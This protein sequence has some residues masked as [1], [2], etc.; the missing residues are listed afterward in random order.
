MLL[1]HLHRSDA[2]I[3][4]YD[5]Q[6]AYSAVQ[7]QCD[8][9]CSVDTCFPS[10]RVRDEW[11]PDQTYVLCPTVQSWPLI[12]GYHVAIGH[13]QG[14]IVLNDVACDLLAMFRYPRTCDASTM[15]NESSETRA[16]IHDLVQL[17]V[18]QPANDSVTPP[19][20]QVL[21]AWLHITD[22]CN[23]RCSYC[24]LPHL[25]KDM[26]LT[27]GR[28][29]IDATF[30]SA[31]RH[32]YAQVKL[33]Y[34]G[35]E[36]LL[37]FKH[38]CTLHRYACQVARECGIALTG[39]ILSNGTLLHHEH[40]SEMRT[41]GLQLMISLD[42]VGVDHDQQ[43]P[44]LHGRG[45]FTETERGISLALT[46]GVIPDIS[47]TVTGK[48]GAALPTLMAWILERDLPF[49]I[50]FYREHDLS[51]TYEDLRC[52]DMQLIAH[53]QAAYQIIESHLPRRSLLNAL[54]D[55]ANGM[56]PH[57]HVCGAGRSYLVFDVNGQV[58]K[59]QMQMDYTVTDAYTE[60][61]LHL[62]RSDSIGVRNISVD[63]K[64]ECQVCTWKQWC[65][66]GCPLVTFRTTGRYDVQSPNCTLYKTLFPAVIRLEG[67]RLLQ[68]GC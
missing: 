43:R 51:A 14:A 66:G 35:G 34:A 22:R 11:T 58:S 60:D 13:D 2:P 6:Q 38:I 62:V 39:V 52:E 64:I 12:P 5:W 28:A 40:L 4:I 27:I 63:D 26:P 53:M 30:R 24:Y 16:V 18:L 61:P 57:Q 56:S 9:A 29:A 15:E 1:T 65:T 23:L 59:C 68:Y 21:S 33:K 20:D 55:R 17:G 46:H 49:H 41:L 54:L 42:G 47:I 45:S 67:L 31:V 36:S 48:N 10:T 8:C 44:D 19:R 3:L 50:N 37:R 25:P 32:Q 7:G